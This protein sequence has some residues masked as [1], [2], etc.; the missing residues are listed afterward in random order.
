MANVVYGIIRCLLLLTAVKATNAQPKQI[1]SVDGVKKIL[2]PQRCRK[3]FL[4]GG[5]QYVFVVQDK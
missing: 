4:I 1:I 3:D 5:A 2:H